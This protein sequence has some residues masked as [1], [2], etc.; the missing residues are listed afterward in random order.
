MGSQGEKETT[1]KV[2]RSRGKKWT[3]CEVLTVVRAF[4][5][6]HEKYTTGISFDKCLTETNRVFLEII[7]SMWKKG[8]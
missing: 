4:L 3:L 1:E 5:V 6:V 7:G 8:E 2:V